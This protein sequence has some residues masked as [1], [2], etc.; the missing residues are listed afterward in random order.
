MY[1]YFDTGEKD[2]DQPIYWE[3]YYSDI[4]DDDYNIN[5]EN[6]NNNIF[7]DSG[8]KYVRQLPVNKEELENRNKRR[9][10]V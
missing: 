3:Q 7:D 8:D 5:S 4:G 6:N 2:N 1:E 9:Q 10:Q